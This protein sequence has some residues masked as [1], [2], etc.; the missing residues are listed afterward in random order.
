MW[1]SDE[2]GDRMK[3]YKK[4]CILLG[5]LVVI[6]VAAFVVSRHEEKKEKIKNMGI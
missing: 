4:L 5:V 1:L 6:C 3:R 2:G